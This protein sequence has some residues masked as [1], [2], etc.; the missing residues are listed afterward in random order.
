MTALQVNEPDT[1][2][3]DLCREICAIHAQLSGLPGLDPE[4]DVN[5][6]FERLVGLCA[7]RDDLDGTQVLADPRVR[8]LAPELRRLCA[9]GEYRLERWWA[10]S[11]LAAADPAARLAEFPYRR[12]YAELMAMEVHALA[13]MGIDPERRERAC[14]VGGGPLPL[15][16]LLL[17]RR[18][19]CPI[20]VVDRDPEAVELAGRLLDRLGASD[21]VRVREA[22]AANLAGIVEDCDTVLLA[23]L[24][25]L[26]RTGKSAILAGL[27]ERVRPGTVLIARGAAGLRRLLYPEVRPVDLRGW[28]PLAE[29]NPFNAV[30][31]SVLVAVRR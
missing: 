13:G 26:D 18:L 4:P 14:F 9:E 30:V 12:N 29:L 21:A 8:D 3:R 25:G 22:D 6:L 31:N 1:A 16:P 7:Y 17:S 20:E 19:R 2:E 11:V 23:A 24:V 15:S 10:H 27:A 5:A 28:R